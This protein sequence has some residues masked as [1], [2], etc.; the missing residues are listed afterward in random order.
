M[1][2]SLQETVN[3]NKVEQQICC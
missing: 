2:Q 1:D 3:S